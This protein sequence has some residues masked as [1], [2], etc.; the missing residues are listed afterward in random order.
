M[1]DG[2]AS[3]V[4]PARSD[5]P[6]P[7]APLAAE[8]VVGRL[9]SLRETTVA[10]GQLFWLE[11]RPAEGGRT[12][13]MG[14]PAHQP[15]G[16]ARERTPGSWDLRTRVHAYGGGS[17][18]CGSGCVVFVH[19]GDRCL[20]RL[21]L[22]GSGAPQRL[23]NP[24]ERC[25]AD[26]L[27]DPLRRRWIGVMEANGRDQLVTVPLDGGEPQQLHP[28]ADFCGYAAISPDG[29]QLAWV[30]WQQPHMPWDRSELWLA[31]LTA[32][33]ELTARRC[34]AGS[35]AEAPQAISV[36]QPLWI[37]PEELVVAE[38]SSGWW[39]LRRLHT[40]SGQWQTL[41][42]LEAE[43]AM[44]QWV[45]GMRTTAWD[46]EH[47]VAA[48][49]REGAWQ[50]G[51]VSLDP[52]LVGTAAAWRPLDQPFDDLA[53]LAAAEGVVACVASSPTSAS[54]LLQL[55]LASGHWQHAPVSD[56]PL[57]LAAISRPEPLWF[58]G[59]GGAPTHA[60]YHPPLGG[61]K[62]TSPLLVKGHSGPT[63]MARRGLQLAIQ[64]W[65]SRGWGVVDVNYGGS[66]GFGRAYRQRLQG[67]WGV[68]DVADCAAAAGALVA[69]G[70][71]SPQRIAIEGGSA[72][73]FT[74]LAALCFTEAFSAAACRYAVCD[75]AALASHDHRFEARY[76]DG[77]IGPWP[78]AAA[79]YA[80]RSPL[81]HA[82]RIRC[83]V[84]LFQGLEDTVV[85]PE[86]TDR[87]AAALAANGIPVEVHHF[88][89]E[90][91]GFRNG[92]VQIQVL[93]ATE[94]FFRRHF[95]LPQP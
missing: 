64:F 7:L 5:P 3:Q 21:D 52:K 69:A 12:T 34:V 46:G 13:L 40:G 44:P 25:F 75:P 45:Y 55:E 90:G 73:G 56:L 42:P 9:P 50:L 47:L 15:H 27:I 53:Y 74:A 87:M 8:R 28:A 93:E 88:A 82:G 32:S 77:L 22:A 71:A 89:G 1:N 60:W 16:V 6:P 57:P 67:Q 17:F 14:R 31:G 62:P 84:I 35:N 10:D 78:E 49:C 59:H 19:D 94:A 41:L 83:P 26:G 85:P 4:G 76:L 91:H 63:G 29:Q 81:L 54:G 18:C 51:E 65:T 70:R 37:G 24:A 48:A 36:F 58:A 61:A 66:T 33:G 39:N 38:D 95:G 80:A 20:W 79:S 68:A 23:T 30:E 92:S 86:Q 11:Q 43:F 72:G 2:L